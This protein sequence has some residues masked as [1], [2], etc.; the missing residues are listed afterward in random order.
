MMDMDML[1]KHVAGGVGRDDPSRALGH[2]ETHQ[3]WC[4]EERRKRVMVWVVYRGL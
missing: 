2:I 1:L 3:R 4:Q